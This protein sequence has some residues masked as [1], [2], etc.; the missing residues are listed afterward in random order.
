ML[1]DVVR[2]CGLETV[3]TTSLATIVPVPTGHLGTFRKYGS[4]K[5]KMMY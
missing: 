4:Y 5:S 1:L 3:W 2:C